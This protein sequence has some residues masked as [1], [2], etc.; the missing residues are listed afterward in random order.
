ML[1]VIG[2]FIPEGTAVYKKIV[3]VLTVVIFNF[4]CNG[5]T[6]DELY[7]DG[8]KAQRKGNSNG[9]IVLFRNALDK[10]QNNLDARY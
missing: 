1:R 2:T 5:K 6:S 7:A 9:A 3:F 4:G 10:N 8:V